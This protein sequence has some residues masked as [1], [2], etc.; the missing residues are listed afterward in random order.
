VYLYNGETGRLVCASCDPTGARPIGGEAPLANAD[1]GFSLAKQN[2]LAAVIPTWTPFELLVSRYQSPYMSDSGRLFFNSDDAL[3]P[4]DV[5]G[6]WD[7]YEYEPLGVPA[8]SVHECTREGATFSPHSEGCIGLISSGGSA[9]ESAYLGASED[10]GDVFF[11][12]SAKLVPQ[13]FDTSLDVY[14]AH[15]CTSALPCFPAPVAQPPECTTTDAC[16]AAP[17]PQPSIFG[18]PASATFNG[19]GNLAPPPASEEVTKKTVKCRSGLVKD[20]KG[21][22]IKKPR[23]RAKAKKAGHGRRA[24]R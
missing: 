12:T 23:R 24:D 9:E 13:D 16:R 21:K 11:L 8:G 2:S 22:C 1:R 15:E 19:A 6:T 14:D 5:N 18:A 4:Q 17:S 20:K 10:G 3:V 7:V